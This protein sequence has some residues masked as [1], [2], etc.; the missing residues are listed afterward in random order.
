MPQRPR[1]D[2]KQTARGI[3]NKKVNSLICAL[4]TFYEKLNKLTQ[5]SVFDQRTHLYETMTRAAVSTL[6][7]II[8]IFV[9]LTPF[10]LRA[11]TLLKLC[12]I[13]T[14]ITSFIE[15]SRHVQRHLIIKLNRILIRHQVL[16]INKQ[17]ISV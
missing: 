3:T 9:A 1:I 4:E 14:Y 17:F 10:F 8:Y 2:L 7:N 5:L 12:L 13:P 6:L 11:S 15:L 16:N